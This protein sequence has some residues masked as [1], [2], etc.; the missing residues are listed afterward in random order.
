MAAFS[1][2][3]DY[4]LYSQTPLDVRTKRAQWDDIRVSVTDW[5]FTGSGDPTAI[6]NYFT[7]G[8]A[9]AGKRAYGFNAGDFVEFEKQ[10]PHGWIQGTNLYPHFHWTPGSRGITESGNTVIWGVALAWY[11][12]DET[13]PAALTSY[14]VTATCDGVDRKYQID[15][16]PL[17]IDGTGKTNSSQLSGI[18]YRKTGGTWSGGP[19][20]GPIL[21]ELDFHALFDSRGS[22]DEFTKTVRSIPIIANDYP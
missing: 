6:S 17:V 9:P 13:M 20:N 8:T 5:Q 21:T 4:R 19:G 3:G 18:I 12:V 2:R 22:D 15:G 7:A 11:N 10:I 14:E 1:T 16:R